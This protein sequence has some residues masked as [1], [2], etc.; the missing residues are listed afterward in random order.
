MKTRLPLLLLTLLFSVRVF[1]Q[2]GGPEE[3]IT[4]R[5]LFLEES[6]GRYVLQTGTGAHHLSSYPYAVSA[7]VRVPRDQRAEVQQI[8]PPDPA[9]DGEGI[10]RLL[11]VATIQPP[12]A[13]ADALVV[14]TPG[15]PGEAHRVRYHNSAPSVFPASS[16]RVINLASELIAVELGGHMERIPPGE[17]RILPARADHRNRVIARVARRG[18]D[19]WHLLYNSVLLLRPGERMTGVVVFS[20]SGMRH[21]YTEAELLEFGDPP[22]RHEWVTFTEKL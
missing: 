12:A 8:L 9:D 13:A 11:T 15:A 10:P 19:D 1:P 20:P 14:L 22:P 21:T 16:L 17:T 7:P 4:L 6:G 3:M 2:G 18:P 5:F